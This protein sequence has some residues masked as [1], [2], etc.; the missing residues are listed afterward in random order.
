MTQFNFG[1]IVATAKSGS[2]L[3]SDLNAWRDAV[4]STHKGP[5]RPTYVVPGMPW[6]SDAVA[7]WSD[8]VYDGAGDA[9]RGF[10]D[11]A[12][13]RYSLAGNY[14]VTRSSGG[15]IAHL[16]DWGTLFNITTVAQTITMDPKSSLLPGW[17][18]RV[19]ARD[20]VVTVD[21]FGG[22]TIDGA[23]NKILSPGSGCTI[24]YDGTNFWS[25]ASSGSSADFPV[26]GFV[27]VPGITPP[28]GFIKANGS[29]LSRTGYAA[30]WTFA[31][32][33]SNMAI[34][35][36]ARTVGQFSPGDGSTNF[37]V[38]DL[39]GQFLRALDDAAGVDAGRA[40]GSSQADGFGSHSHTA[41]SGTISA[42]HYHSFADSSSSTSSAGSHAH[43]VNERLAN[44][45]AGSIPIATDYA[46]AQDTMPTSTAGAHAHTVA[47]SGNTG[48]SS[49]NHT[50]AITVNPIGGAETRPK[51]LA[52]LACIKY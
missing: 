40:L 2:G 29:L 42:D 39:R 20:V 35:D 23:A 4:H 14:A 12:T 49:A 31:Q 52:M 36:G 51:N 33:S 47:V 16:S 18:I 30:L 9:L 7:P 24:F 15:V 22:E 50:H 43:T 13:H 41:S 19:V 38:P 27:Y 1:T 25:D 10:I 32:S 44:I 11:P 37:R 34:S 6:I 8:F 46:A 48:Y 3:A 45:G 17:W 5:I 28:Q 21:P 26:G